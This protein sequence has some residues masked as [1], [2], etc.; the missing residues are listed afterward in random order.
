MKVISEEGLLL[1]EEKKWL[2]KALN[3]DKTII[4]EIS[5]ELFGTVGR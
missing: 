4:G 3:K 2:I 5:D 1:E